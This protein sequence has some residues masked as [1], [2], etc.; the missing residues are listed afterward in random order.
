LDDKGFE[1]IHFFGDKV[2]EGG[3]DYELFV[4]PKTVGHAVK[5][6]QDT[7]EQLLGLFPDMRSEI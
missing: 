1:E 4:H 6:P 3:N 2:T 5:D 7:V